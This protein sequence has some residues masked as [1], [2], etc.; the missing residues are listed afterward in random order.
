VPPSPALMQRVLEGKAT[1]QERA[2]FSRRWQQNVAA[3]LSAHADPE[4]V[5]VKPVR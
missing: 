1:P 5:R 4:L 3:I 2:S